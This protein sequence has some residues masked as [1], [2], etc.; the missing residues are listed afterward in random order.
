MTAPRLRDAVPPRARLNDNEPKLAVVVGVGQDNISD[1]FATLDDERVPTLDGDRE[2]RRGRAKLHIR[3]PV[4]VLGEILVLVLG[5]ELG[6]QCRRPAL[7]KVELEYFHNLS[8]AMNRS[9][10]LSTKE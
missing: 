6:G 3:R 4:F 10:G 7:W 9:I 1:D 2:W 5:E 8:D